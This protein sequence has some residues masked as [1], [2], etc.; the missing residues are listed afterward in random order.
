M[1]TTIEVLVKD[2]YGQ[3]VYHPQNDNAYIFAKIAGTK[4]L[5]NSTLAYAKELGYAIEFKF[6]TVTLDTNR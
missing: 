5:T 3:R 6:E 2:Q 1:N 4:T